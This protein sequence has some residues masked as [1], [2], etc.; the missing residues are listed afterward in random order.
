MGLEFDGPEEG[1]GEVSNIFATARE[2]TNPNIFLLKDNGIALALLP[3]QTST[4]D[5]PL[6][7]PPIK[8]APVPGSMQRAKIE[9][10]APTNPIL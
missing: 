7:D 2:D 1:T 9:P 4:E 3:N 5:K 8:R 6:K 10:G